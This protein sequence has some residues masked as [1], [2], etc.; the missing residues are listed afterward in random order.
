MAV[1]KLEKPAAGSVTFK[2][3][4]VIPTDRSGELR[5]GFLVFGDGTTDVKLIKCGVRLK[6]GKALLVQGPLESGKTQSLAL[7][8]RAG[9]EMTITVTVDLAAQQVTYT[10]DGATLTAR[11]ERPLKAITHVG[12]AAERAIVDFTPIDVQAD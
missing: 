11:L 3:R 4:M 2:T 12:Y 10:A 1:H 9:Q 8:V 5:N 7:D 6:V